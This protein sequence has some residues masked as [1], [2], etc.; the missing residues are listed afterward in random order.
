MGND[1]E[2]PDRLTMQ[3]GEVDRDGGPAGTEPSGDT[4]SGE[5][6]GT[7]DNSETGHVGESAGS[8]RS[9][10]RIWPWALALGLAVAGTFAVVMAQP[11]EPVVTVSSLFGPTGQPVPSAP[12]HQ[13]ARRWFRELPP[14]TDLVGVGIH[15]D[16]V[17]AHVSPRSQD[18]D[19]R[20]STVLAWDAAT[21]D[22]VWT[23]PLAW[24]RQVDDGQHEPA[25]P[26]VVVLDG[27]LTT[28]GS[29]PSRRGVPT[30]AILA[31]DAGDGSVA[32]SRLLPS[33]GVVG[34]YPDRQRATIRTVDSRQTADPDALGLGEV[35]VD[36]AD[37]EVVFVAEGT[38]VPRDGGWFSVD[39]D[40]GAAQRWAVVDEDGT[41][42]MRVASDAAPAMLGEFVVTT[43][44]TTITA[45][46]PTGNPAWDAVLP[47]T[48]TVPATEVFV[49]LGA[50]GDDTLVA[51]AY[52]TSDNEVGRL[53]D[54]VTSR[55]FRD[56]RIE[57][58]DDDFVRQHALDTGITMITVDGAPLLACAARADDPGSSCPAPLA[59]VDLDGTVTARVD[60]VVVLRGP[61]DGIPL[62]GM[63]TTR[64][65]V[66]VEPDALRLRSWVDLAPLWEIEVPPSQETMIATSGTG[67]AVGLAGG[68]PSVTWLS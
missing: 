64:G 53:Q 16:L 59:L 55:V 32:W 7:G 36:L 35:V 56:G 47:G 52:R 46:T 67:V 31:L 42:T 10:H 2:A 54:Y 57:E 38:L 6:D 17:V 23:T 37:G 28:A 49:A 50:V 22:V 13:V 44:G 33:P 58:L 1:G 24:P 62:P 65:L 66:V 15:G 45:T 51:G 61:A 48:G 63:A 68:T 30:A 5:V 8:R 26:V 14:G 9:A 21:G 12:D 19:P 39:L 4:P 29:D 25:P 11:Q 40:P 18:D 43:E 34:L 20:T 3:V 60:D 27:D 41:I